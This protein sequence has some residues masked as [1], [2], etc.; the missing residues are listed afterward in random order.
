VRRRRRHPPLGSPPQ[1]SKRCL[2]HRE[3]DVRLS[4]S[5]VQPQP[6]RYMKHP[7]TR[8]QPPLLMPYRSFQFP[9]RLYEQVSL[10]FRHPLCHPK[11]TAGEDSP[12]STLDAESVWSAVTARRSKR[13][14]QTQPSRVKPSSPRHRNDSEKHKPWRSDSSTLLQPTPFIVLLPPPRPIPL[15]KSAAIDA[16]SP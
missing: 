15:R 3:G 16:K 2:L 14:S 13:P 9:F 11:L 5:E 7:T 10:S 4:A 12:A 1:Q 8:L 6:V